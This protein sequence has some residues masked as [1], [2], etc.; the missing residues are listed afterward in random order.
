MMEVKIVE[1]KP[2]EGVTEE[3]ILE[4]AKAEPVKTKE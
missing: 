1:K 2:E 4:A 3:Q